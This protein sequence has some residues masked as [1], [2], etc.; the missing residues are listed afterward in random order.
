MVELKEISNMENRLGSIE[1]L[2]EKVAHNGIILGGNHYNME[3][4][5]TRHGG[6]KGGQYWYGGRTSMFMEDCDISDREKD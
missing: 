3:Y 1:W 2:S 6:G 4:K 5:H